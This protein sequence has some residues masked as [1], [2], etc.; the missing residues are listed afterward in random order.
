MS[1]DELKLHMLGRATRERLLRRGL[2]P[3][4]IEDRLFN[5]GNTR[6]MVLKVLL[7]KGYSPKDSVKIMEYTCL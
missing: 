3:E 7:D 1:Q 2:S 6:D 5:P 4:I